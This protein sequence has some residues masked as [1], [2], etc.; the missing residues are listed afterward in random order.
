MY[1]Q[2]QDVLEHN[3]MHI[4]SVVSPIIVPLWDHSP[5][6]VWIR[7][8]F[9]ITWSINNNHK[10]HIIVII[11][12]SCQQIM[13]SLILKNPF[14]NIIYI[15]PSTYKM[16]CII[17]QAR[18]TQARI[19]IPASGCLQFKFWQW[20]GPTIGREGG[21][22]GLHCLNE[23]QAKLNPPLNSETILS[24]LLKSR[25]VNSMLCLQHSLDQIR[26]RLRIYYTHAKEFIKNHSLN[27]MMMKTECQSCGH[28]AIEPRQ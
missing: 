6:K 7:I 8:G 21:K 1:T 25:F 9:S 11:F 2:H 17:T 19:I 23:I 5:R 22:T 26:V 13:H 16:L 27:H 24:G 20:V 4:C 12:P 15:A 28:W 18:I 3:H 10:E 14:L